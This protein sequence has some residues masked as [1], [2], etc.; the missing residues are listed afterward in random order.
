MAVHSLSCARLNRLR[1]AVLAVARPPQVH[2]GLRQLESSCLLTR[3]P[4]VEISPD[5]L[6]PLLSALLLFLENLPGDDLA[7]AVTS[8]TILFLPYIFFGN[9]SY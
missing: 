5:F 6:L 2:P 7:L 1:L 8:R 3:N 9:A 4:R